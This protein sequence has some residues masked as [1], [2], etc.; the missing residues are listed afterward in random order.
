[1]KTRDEIEKE[2]NT[3]LPS[4]DAQ[5]WE[6]ASKER[7]LLLEV[8]LDVRDLIVARFG[9]QLSFPVP[10][11]N[12]II[13]GWASSPEE[14]ARMQEAYTTLREGES[15]ALAAWERLRVEDERVGRQHQ[16][17]EVVDK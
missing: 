2:W 6:Y 12:G 3:R 7:R 11:E 13:I 4:W 9:K 1:M 16:P 17:P 8:L 15:Y 10:D 14:A 5:P